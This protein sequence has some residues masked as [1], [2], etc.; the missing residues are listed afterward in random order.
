MEEDL[1]KGLR[2][3]RRPLLRS[4]RW[5]CP[6]LETDQIQ[7]LNFDVGDVNVEGMIVE[8]DVLV[9]SYQR[10]F[11][12]VFVYYCGCL[13]LLCELGEVRKDMR[14]QSANRFVS[15]VRAR[16]P[17]GYLYMELLPGLRLHHAGLAGHEGR[18]ALRSKR[19]RHISRSTL[20]GRHRSIFS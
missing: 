7:C 3:C 1:F 11:H 13:S 16:V 8:R 6:G 10:H 12:V 5:P 17:A 15:C 2:H 14:L 20:G 4:P 19:E 18:V 9:H